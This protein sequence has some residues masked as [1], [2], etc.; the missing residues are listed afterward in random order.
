MNINTLSENHPLRQDPQRP[1]P[2]VVLVG[3]RAA[4]SRKIVERSRQHVRATSIE[5]AMRAGITAAR[6]SGYTRHTKDGRRLIPSRALSAR[7]LDQTDA[8][9]GW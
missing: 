2:Y 4:G 7:P 6:E 9:S 8:I 1:W 5:A 3:Y